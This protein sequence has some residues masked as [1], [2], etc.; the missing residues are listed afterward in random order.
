MALA[1][2]SLGTL[3]TLP[4]IFN[5]RI[6]SLI[7]YQWN[8][9][10]TGIHTYVLWVLI[11][12]T[13]YISQI[14][15]NVDCLAKLNILIFWKKEPLLSMHWLSKTLLSLAAESPKLRPP[16]KIQMEGPGTWFSWSSCLLPPCLSPKIKMR[17][18]YLLYF[19]DSV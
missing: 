1:S 8:S 6:F 7:S 15:I 5:I 12:L 10:A 16:R 14:L 19:K 3:V 13:I 4:L 18:E 17:L 2:F 9:C 11:S